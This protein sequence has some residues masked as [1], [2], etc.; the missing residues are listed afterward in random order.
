MTALLDVE[1]SGAAGELVDT[2]EVSGDGWKL[3]ALNLEGRRVGEVPFRKNADGISF[4]ADTF[5]PNGDALLAYEL[6]RE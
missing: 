5:G 2:Y 1:V 4:T 6:V 3:Y